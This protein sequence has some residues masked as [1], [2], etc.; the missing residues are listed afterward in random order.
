MAGL[1][2]LV[3]YLVTTHMNRETVSKMLPYLGFG[4]SH[5]VNFA[6]EL[7]ADSVP[8]EEFMRYYNY[9]LKRVDE[10]ANDYF[11]MPAQLALVSSR[12][13]QILDQL[14][15]YDFTEGPDGKNLKA[16]VES[17]MSEGA[18]SALKRYDEISGYEME[19][20]L[21]TKEDKNAMHQ[22]SIFMRNR[23]FAQAI[24]EFSRMAGLNKYD[25]VAHGINYSIHELYREDPAL[26]KS[27]LD[28]ARLVVKGK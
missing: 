24:A 14:Y 16:H 20:G 15:S 25:S 12:Q 21:V 9:L 4:Q 23:Q 8:R 26:V 19:K 28:Q 27:A 7:L 18:T 2:V 17:V 13:I 10:Q 1:C 3:V 22:A 6:M 11:S 5:R